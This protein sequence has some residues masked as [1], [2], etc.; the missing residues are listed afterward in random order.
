MAISRFLTSGMSH[1]KTLL[2]HHNFMIRP[3]TGVYESK[4][5]SSIYYYELLILSALEEVKVAQQD[6]LKLLKTFHCR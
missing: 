4:M 1:H 5:L 6:V 3:S 2:L